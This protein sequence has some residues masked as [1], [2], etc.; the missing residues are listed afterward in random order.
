MKR[1]ALFTLRESI[2]LG[3]RRSLFP[4]FRVIAWSLNAAGNASLDG[5]EVVALGLSLPAPGMT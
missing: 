3:A 5:L 4:L 1:Y 2:S